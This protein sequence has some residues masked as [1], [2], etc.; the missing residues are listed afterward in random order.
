V[1]F[2]FVPQPLHFSSRVAVVATGVQRFN[3]F[4]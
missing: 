3:P 4:V 2:N 1:L